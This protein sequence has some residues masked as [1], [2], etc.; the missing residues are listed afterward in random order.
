MTPDDHAPELVPPTIPDADIG[1][2]G[3]VWIPNWDRH[4]VHYKNRARH[5]MAWIKNL[6]RLL[7]DDAYLDLNAT[8]RALL[9]GL[10]MLVGQTGQG[11]CSARTDSLQRA[12]VLARGQVRPALVRLNHAGFVRIIASKLP[13]TDDGAASNEERRG[14]SEPSKAHLS[15]TVEGGPRSRSRAAHAARHELADTTNGQIDDTATATLRRTLATNR[16][17]I[18]LGIHA[19]RY[20]R[21]DLAFLDDAQYHELELEA[22]DP[23]DRPL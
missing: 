9:H 11:R 13:L 8:D 6:T 2:C 20:Q 21:T 5:N 15:P 4:Y 7:H 22:T 16:P 14:E 19:G 10:W 3:Y 12:L 23:E 18:V 17:A 1:S